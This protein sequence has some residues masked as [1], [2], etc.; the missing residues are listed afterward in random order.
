MG[1]RVDKRNQRQSV[2]AVAS[3]AE[4]YNE[5]SHAGEV[6]RYKGEARRVSKPGAVRSLSKF[7]FVRHFTVHGINFQLDG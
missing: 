6:T 3:V 7:M 1:V 4:F 2:E 5:L